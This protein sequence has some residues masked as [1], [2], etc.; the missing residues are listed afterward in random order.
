MPFRPSA[1]SRAEDH[2][3]QMPTTWSPMRTLG[4]RTHVLLR[5]SPRRSA[6]SPRSPGPGTAPLLRPRQ[7]AAGIG[8][9]HGPLDGLLRRHRSAA[10]T[11][12]DGMTGWEALDHWG[13]MIAGAGRRDGRARLAALLRA[14]RCR[15]LGRDL[16]R[17]GVA[18]DARRS[19]RGSWSTRPGANGASRAAAAARL[20]AGT[21]ADRAASRCASGVADARRCGARSPQRTY[22][23]RRPR[24]AGADG[25]GT[26]PA[27]SASSG[28]RRRRA[29]GPAGPAGSR[30]S[31]RSARP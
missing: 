18:R 20:L 22:Q 16:A 29:G 12:G 19:S 24:P 17:Y 5:S 3:A 4:F 15:S 1:R 6:S 8:D 26:R 13:Q 10:F 31:G 7:D 2:D 21:F 30:R 25:V 11:S 27:P 28:R 9:M 14:A 23:R